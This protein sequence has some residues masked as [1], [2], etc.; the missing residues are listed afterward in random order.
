M[1]KFLASYDE[2]YIALKQRNNVFTPLVFSD[3]TLLS[4]CSLPPPNHLTHLINRGSMRSEQQP[5]P[6]AALCVAGRL[7]RGKKESAQDC[8]FFSGIPRGSLGGGQR[9]IA[10][11]QAETVK[12]VVDNELMNCQAVK[13]WGAIVAWVQIPEATPYSILVELCCGSRSCSRTFFPLL[14]GSLSPTPPPSP[15]SPP[16]QPCQQRFL[17]RRGS[18]HL[19]SRSYSRHLRSYLMTATRT[20]A[21]MLK[22][23]PERKK[24]LPFEWKFL[25]GM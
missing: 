21:Q 18:K 24:K 4:E 2:T 7:A 1:R 23:M 3:F 12:L 14:L 13:Y 16:P 6:S 20:T 17:S 10:V 25:S 11:L 19:Q 15:P 22:S 8:H 9:S 5:L